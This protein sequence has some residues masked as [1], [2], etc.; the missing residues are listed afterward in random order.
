MPNVIACRMA[1][2]GKYQDRA[3][4]HLPQIGI[5][6]VEMPVPAPD[7]RDAVKARLADHGLTATSLQAKC[8]IGG[9]DAAE[10]MTPQLEACAEFGARICFLSV[11]AGD[12]ERS[13]V[14]DRLRAI[15]DAAAKLDVTVVMETHPDLITNGDVARETMAAIDHPHVRVNF[16]TANIYFYNQNRTAVDELAK[17]ID[18]VAAVHLKDTTGG[19]QEWNFPTL[20][21]GVVDFPAVFRLLGARGFTGPFTIELEG[22]KGVERDEAG[23]LQY[24][25]DSVAYLR[26]IGGLG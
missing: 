19:Y 22:T 18:F 15:G 4:S 6:N 25:A 7:Q 13:E 1:S 23:Q 20:G 26:R 5:R 12:T 24:V 8:D 11:K 21:T 2:Y 17:V 16:D 3:W 9:A 10:V 14:W